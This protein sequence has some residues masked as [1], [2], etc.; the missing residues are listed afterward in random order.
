[1]S[2][3]V[4]KNA[5]FASLPSSCRSTIWVKGKAWVLCAG[6]SITEMMRQMAMCGTLSGVAGQPTA[7]LEPAVHAISSRQA[8]RVSASTTKE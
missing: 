1:M 8:G 5:L 4:P 7:L 6:T 3:Q 2:M